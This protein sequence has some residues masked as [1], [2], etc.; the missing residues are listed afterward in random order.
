MFMSG[1]PCENAPVDAPVY[2]LNNRMKSPSKAE[3]AR[4]TVGDVQQRQ[5]LRVGFIG[6]GHSNF[7]MRLSAN[8][9]PPQ[10][11]AGGH[12]LSCRTKLAVKAARKRPWIIFVMT[13]R[14]T[15]Q[16]TGL[17]SPPLRPS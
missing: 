8:V 11:P 14:Q 13:H 9:Q 15:G 3:P 1:V 12:R 2:R 7:E 5:H 16:T 10:R 17:A 4:K 6:S